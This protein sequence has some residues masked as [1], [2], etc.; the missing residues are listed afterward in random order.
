M[1]FRRRIEVRPKLTTVYYEVKCEK[2]AKVLPEQEGFTNEHNLQYDNALILEL[3]G[4]YGMFI[5]PVGL[6]SDGDD[7]YPPD[8]GFNPATTVILCHE[9]AHDL[10]LWLGL[11]PKNWHTHSVNSGQHPNHHDEAVAEQ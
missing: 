5:D 3:H 9:C 10:S 2:C 6:E 7:V 4:G 8:A 11:N 1:G